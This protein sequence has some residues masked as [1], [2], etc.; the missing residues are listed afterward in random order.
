MGVVDGEAV[1]RAW[2]WAYCRLPVA[3][4][5]C[6]R[7]LVDRL[8]RVYFFVHLYFLDCFAGKQCLATQ[9]A[10]VRIRPRLNLVDPRVGARTGVAMRKR[11]PALGGN[12]VTSEDKIPGGRG[13]L[14]Y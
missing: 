5:C 11:T 2:G 12:L 9:I 3:F 4:G 8:S 6:W 10:S 1:V 7:S 13:N 14:N